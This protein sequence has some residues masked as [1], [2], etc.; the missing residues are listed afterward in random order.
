MISQRGGGVEDGVRYQDVA[1]NTSSDRCWPTRHTM[2]MGPHYVRSMQTRQSQLHM[3][4]V[5]ETGLVITR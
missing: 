1:L 4:Y 3:S 2:Q 5:E